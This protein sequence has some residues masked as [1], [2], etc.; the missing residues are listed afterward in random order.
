MSGLAGEMDRPMRPS[1]SVGRPLVTL[2]HETPPSVD[3]QIAL[4]GPPSMSVQVTTALVR[5][6]DEDVGIARVD[7][8][9]ADAGVLA[10][11]EHLLPRLSAIGGPVQPTVAAGTPERPLRGDLHHVAVARIEDDLCRCVRSA[12]APPASSSCH[13]PRSGRRHRR[14]RHCAASSPRR[15]PPRQCSVA[16]GRRRRHRWN[17]SPPGRRSESTSHHR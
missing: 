10:D 3:L 9:V 7:R 16:W 2:L 17:R 14:M 15:C 4:S 8:H 5:G 11:G 1:S 12:R 13:R 6:G